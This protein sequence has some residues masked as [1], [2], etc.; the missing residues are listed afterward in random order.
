MSHQIN[1][2]RF[3]S[4]A[5]R[6]NPHACLLGSG[7]AFGGRA[8]AEIGADLLGQLGTVQRIEMQV[9]DATCDEGLAEFSALLDREGGL[10]ARSVS[11]THLTL[12]TNREV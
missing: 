2:G 9:L 10:A 4:V 3:S 12:P 11:Y 1:S 5:D 6:G 7:G 8:N